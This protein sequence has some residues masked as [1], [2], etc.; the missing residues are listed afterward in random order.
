MTCQEHLLT[1]LCVRLDPVKGIFMT[2][3]ASSNSQIFPVLTAPFTTIMLDTENHI[4]T[5]AESRLT[6]DRLCVRMGFNGPLRLNPCLA[7]NQHT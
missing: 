3:A 7:L 2:S 6:A 4:G 1:C 5:G